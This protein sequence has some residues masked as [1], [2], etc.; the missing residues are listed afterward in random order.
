MARWIDKSPEFVAARYNRFAPVYGLLDWLQG[1]PLIGLRRK[2]VAALRL[3]CGDTVLEVGC[4]DGRC[5]Y[6]LQ[7]AVGSAGRIIG[8]DVSPKMLARADRLA[9]HRGWSNVELHCVNAAEFTP[10]Q[11]IQGALFTLSYC[12]MRDR[13]AIL[14][15]V[16]DLLEPRGRLVIADVMMNPGIPRRFFGWL[17]VLVSDLSLL[18]KPDI[19]PR[20]DLASNAGQVEYQRILR[21]PFLQQFEVC[22]A[23][24]SKPE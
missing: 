21:F 13:S 23:A 8:I 2:A 12:T 14:R 19:E 16:W 6:L 15:R 20:S 17:G 4:G 18:G 3:K 9:R 7:G 10:P 1:I 22:A 11:P 24:K 5:F